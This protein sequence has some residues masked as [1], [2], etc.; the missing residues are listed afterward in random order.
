M[1]AMGL[2]L[3]GA[4]D[5][6][7]ERYELP[8]LKDDEILAEVQSNGI[9]MSSHK[10][11]KQGTAH[12]RVP[13][14]IAENP[15]LMGHEFCGT[16]LEVGP[17]WRDRV[18]PG[19][20]YGVQPALN[21]PGREHEAP[22]YSFPY[23][24]GQA[25]HIIIPREVMEMDCLLPYDGDAYFKAS[26]SE[27]FSCIIGAYKTSYHHAAGSYVHESGIVVGGQ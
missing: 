14:D 9:C 17:K 3:Y 26:L 22:G 25:T 16:I 13:K 15:I 1:Q 11:T 18:Q 23:I 19:Q 8:A 7:L 21:I 2:R 24:G 20:K 5:L 6:R 27:T 10:A 4:D 12:K